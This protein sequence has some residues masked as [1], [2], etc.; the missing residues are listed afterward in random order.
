MRS[1]DGRLPRPGFVIESA[2]AQDGPLE[3]VTLHEVLVRL[4]FPLHV[5]SDVPANARRESDIL[6]RLYK[7]TSKR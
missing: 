3:G 1:T 4:V 7:F 2:R 5:C 6:L